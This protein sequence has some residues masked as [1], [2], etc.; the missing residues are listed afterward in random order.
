MKHIITL[1]AIAITSVTLSSNVYGQDQDNNSFE[2][3]DIF[4]YS[5]DK[6]EIINI[7]AGGIVTKERDGK[8]NPGCMFRINYHPRVNGN[9]DCTITFINSTGE[10]A[11]IFSGS[12]R[13]LT[14]VK[15]KCKKNNWE[16]YNYELLDR[17]DNRILAFIMMDYGYVYID[18]FGD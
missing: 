17:Y 14:L 10:E 15:F 2:I 8:F 1:I 13:I 16:Y 5:Y 7:P 11:E 18:D 9:I 4:T 12:S 6:Y 3:L